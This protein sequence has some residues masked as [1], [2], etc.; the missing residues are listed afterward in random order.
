MKAIKSFKATWRAEFEKEFLG[1]SNTVD[2]DKLPLLEAKAGAWYYVTYHPHEREKDMSVEGGF[3]SFPWVVYE[4]ICHIAKKNRSQMDNFD[5]LTPIAE[6]NIKAGKLELL[7][8]RNDVPIV[9]V[10]DEDEQE[11]TEDSSESSD[12]EIV[13]VNIYRTPTSVSTITASLDRMNLREN[14][15]RKRQAPYYAVHGQ[16][17]QGVK[18][19]RN[20]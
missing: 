3:L 10:V 20:T 11:E 6:E 16:R 4:Y 13:N 5:A 19:F 18:L 9:E 7:R 15:N 14:E 1:P 17:H 8:M 12:E 2:P